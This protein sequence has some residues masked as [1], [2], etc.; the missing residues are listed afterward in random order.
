MRA[1]AARDVKP[2]RTRDGA[3]MA[4]VWRWS[5]DTATWLGDMCRNRAR[6]RRRLRHFI[7]SLDALQAMVP[8]CAKRQRGSARADD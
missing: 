7:L 8:R 2:T 1:S 6:Y 5:Q 4:S 3:Q